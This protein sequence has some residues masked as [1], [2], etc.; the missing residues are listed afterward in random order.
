MLSGQ[1][2]S[3]FWKFIVTPVLHSLFGDVFELLLLHNKTLQLQRHEQPVF[4]YAHGFCR[5]GIQEGTSNSGLPYSVWNL[6]RED[7]KAEG[8][9]QS[10]LKTGLVIWRSEYIPKCT[11][12]Y[13]GSLFHL[14]VEKWQANVK[15][16][17]KPNMWKWDMLWSSLEITICYSMWNLGWPSSLINLPVF[18]NM[19]ILTGGDKSLLS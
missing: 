17:K 4:Y 8:E 13:K 10:P 3:R 2:A 19:E 16:T 14:L 7:S 15:D 1:E 12:L 9:D 11:D 18:Q 5:L 6:I